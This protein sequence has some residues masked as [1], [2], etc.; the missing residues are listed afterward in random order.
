[1]P[2]F[3]PL[4]PSDKDMLEEFQKHIYDLGRSLGNKV[5]SDIVEK[6]K[7]QRQEEDSE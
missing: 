5:D 6:L 2:M 1:M 3:T 7:E 4:G